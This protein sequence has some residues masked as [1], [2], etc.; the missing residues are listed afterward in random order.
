MSHSDRFFIYRILTDFSRIA[1]VRRVPQ[2][3]QHSHPLRQSAAHM[4]CPRRKPA[5]YL[6]LPRVRARALQQHDGEGSS[7]LA[8]RAPLR[9][10]SHY[11]PVL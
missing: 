8:K 1:V 10:H 3:S 5:A 2:A 4:R 6:V 7:R 11:P 9:F